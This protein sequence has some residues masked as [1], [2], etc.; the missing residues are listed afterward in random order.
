MSMHYIRS[1]Y[2]IITSVRA[3]AAKVSGVQ[4]RTTFNVK[5]H[6][7]LEKAENAARKWI[8][9]KRRQVDRNRATILAVPDYLLSEVVECLELLEPYNTRI[10]DVVREYVY[11][12]EPEP[13]T[14]PWRFSEAATSFISSRRVAGRRKEYLR[15]L[16]DF[17]NLTAK[18][19]GDQLLDEV[20]TEQLE[21]WLSERGRKGNPISP[22]TFRNY[23]RDLRMLWRFARERN[24]VAHDP[25]TPIAIPTITKEPVKILTPEQINN[26]LTAAGDTI[27]S[28]IAVLAFA[29]IRPFEILQLRPDSVDDQYRFLTIEGLHAKSRK[30][31]LVTIPSNLAAWLRKNNG[32]GQVRNYWRL[33][34]MLCSAAQ[35]ANVSLTQD[36]LRHSFASHHL[37]LHQNAALT[38]HE[39]GHHNQQMLFEHYREVVSSDQANAYFAIIP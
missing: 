8:K 3:V 33:R 29:G 7:S 30:R 21:Q 18:T 26:L 23:R 32:L 4:I 17:F 11:R 15:A 1:K 24:R 5:R 13:Q 10:I 9:E 6:G 2:G 19:F 37:A 22:I 20:T 35:T 14:L 34:G 12:P 25:V 28:Y 39:L 27:Q 36:I 38:A 16:E 31:R